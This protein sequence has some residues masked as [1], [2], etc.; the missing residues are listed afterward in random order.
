MNQQKVNEF[1]GQA[2]M[3]SQYLDLSA[4]IQ[5]INE[6]DYKFEKNE[7]LDIIKGFRELKYIGLT[8]NKVSELISII[9]EHYQPQSI[10]DI[11]CGIGNILSYFKNNK[12]I[13][14]IDVNAGSIKMAQY[15]NPNA[16]FII[17]DTL[18]HDFNNEKYDLVIGHFPFS[19]KISDRKLLELELIDIGLKLL[20]INGVAIFVVTDNLLTS[21]NKYS[22]EFR[23]K[24]L[25]NF[26]LDMVISLP[27]GVFP[28]AG[29]KTSILVVR[30]SKHREDIFMPNFEGDPFQLVKTAFR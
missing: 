22:S 9:G 14:G 12:T 15:I 6:S 1:I 29:V 7:V 26:S 24:L 23:K 13:N 8:P 11:C 3:S 17:G 16:N 5:K 21:S 20:N 18:N 25:T 27:V 10:I 30:N 19:V 28:Y 4:I 2:R